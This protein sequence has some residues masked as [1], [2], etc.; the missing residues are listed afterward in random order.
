MKIEHI[1]HLADP[2]VETRPICGAYLTKWVS[3]LPTRDT[4][5]VNCPVCLSIMA[6]NGPVEPEGAGQVR[7]DV[8]NREAMRRDW[9]VACVGGDT[10]LGFM[11]WMRNRMGVEPTTPQRHKPPRMEDE[12]GMTDGVFEFYDV[13]INEGEPCTLEVVP[14]ASGNVEITVGYGPDDGY[15][16]TLSHLDRADM[17]RALLHD[18]H[19]SPERGGPNDD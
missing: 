9:T 13:H 12:R 18:F 11:D 14:Q 5:R 15:M 17:M 3:P 6:G 1:I 10:D 7:G 19:Y 16:F 8:S 4:V 2:A